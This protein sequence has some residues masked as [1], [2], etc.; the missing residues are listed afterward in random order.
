M[1]DLLIYLRLPRY[2]KEWL[3]F[4]LGTPVRFPERSY[5]NELLHTLLT[6]RPASV[7]PVKPTADS[8]AMVIT[9]C[10]H[11][12]PEHY[13]YLGIRGQ[14]VMI[15]SIEGLF[16]LDLWSGC[17]PLLHS[18]RELNKGIDEWCRA[19]G[20]CHEPVWKELRLSYQR[21]GPQGRQGDRHVHRAE[22]D[23]IAAV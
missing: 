5:E 10:R 23:R 9:D 2:L 1:K 11:R 16:R 14:R 12:K 22:G 6:K 18:R 4:H 20:I 13:N 17:A 19:N 21:Q 7:Q 8:V 15:S 3:E